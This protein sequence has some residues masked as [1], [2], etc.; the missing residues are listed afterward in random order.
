VPVSLSQYE[1]ALL[2]LHN[3][4][5]SD[6]GLQPFVADATLEQIARQRAQTMAQS[7]SFS[8]YNPDGTDLFDMMK[9]LGYQYT[10]AAENIH[11]NFGYDDAQSVQVA[12]TAFMNSAPHRANI[13]KADLHRIGIGI[14]HASDGKV[15]YAV[16]FSN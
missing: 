5:R 4:A 11:Y 1:G 15:Y 16:D 10:D 8:H 3:Q 9:A 13:L 14:A 6:N 2:Q 7:G 12:M